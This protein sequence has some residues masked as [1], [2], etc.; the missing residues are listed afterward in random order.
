MG[1]GVVIKQEKDLGSHTFKKSLSWL[2]YEG[3][4]GESEGNQLELFQLLGRSWGMGGGGW[5]VETEMERFGWD[6]EVFLRQS[7][8]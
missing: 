4:W 1:A 7:D 8:I 2:L 3:L 5:V 6:Q